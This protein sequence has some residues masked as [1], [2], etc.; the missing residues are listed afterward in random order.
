MRD[1]EVDLTSFRTDSPMDGAL[2]AYLA[3]REGQR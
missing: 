2:T 1:Y 3:K